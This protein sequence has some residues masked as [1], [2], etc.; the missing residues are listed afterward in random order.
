[1]LSNESES[2]NQELKI[3]TGNGTSEGAITGAVTLDLIIGRF[4]ETLR[5]PKIWV[6]A[7]FA[8]IAWVSYPHVNLS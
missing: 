8:A 6:M 4:I 1:M 3:S 5:D 7:L 2:T